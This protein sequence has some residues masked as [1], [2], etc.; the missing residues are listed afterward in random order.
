MKVFKELY[1]DAKNIQ[2]KERCINYDESKQR[3]KRAKITVL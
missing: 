3:K 1:E 2:K